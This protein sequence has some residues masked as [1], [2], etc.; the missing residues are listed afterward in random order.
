[1]QLVQRDF[2]EL[3]N[4]EQKKGAFKVTMTLH[5][6]LKELLPLEQFNTIRTDRWDRLARKYLHD[7]NYEPNPI[8]LGVAITATLK[9]AKQKRQCWRVPPGL[10]KSRIIA[11]ICVIMAK[12][13]K[14]DLKSVY[15]AFPSQILLDTDKGLYE[16]L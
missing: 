13:C 4:Q 14:K 10:G 11:A 12:D 1:M 5:Q 6:K 9:F 15:I 2:E 16:K 8:Q 7:M 3:V